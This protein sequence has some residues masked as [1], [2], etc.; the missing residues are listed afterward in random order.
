MNHSSLLE[1]IKNNRKK[2]DVIPHLYVS[3]GSPCLNCEEAY[4]PNMNT[5]KYEKKLKTDFF[6]KFIYTTKIRKF[7]NL[8]KK[9]LQMEVFYI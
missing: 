5:A 3:T 1:P 8:P 4:A 6:I 7:S 9:N 2:K